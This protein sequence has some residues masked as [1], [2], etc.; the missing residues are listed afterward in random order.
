MTPPSATGCRVTADQVEPED[1]SDER[2]SNVGTAARAPAGGAAPVSRV[3]G[4]RPSAHLDTSVE[5]GG[6][7]VVAAIP[8]GDER[9]DVPPVVPVTTTG[10][11]MPGT[12][13]DPDADVA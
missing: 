13:T 2:V 10:A 5:N 6:G 7:A 1:G 11:P 12:A 3:S 4:D 9:G 8:T